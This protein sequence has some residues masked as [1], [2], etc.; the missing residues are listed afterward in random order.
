MG[1]SAVVVGDGSTGFVTMNLNGFVMMIWVYRT[2]KLCV[3][4]KSWTEKSGFVPVW[5]PFPSSN[6]KLICTSEYHV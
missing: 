5:C 1:Y 2:L 4:L 6:L 3:C